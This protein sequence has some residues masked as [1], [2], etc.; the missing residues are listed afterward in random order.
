MINNQVRDECIAPAG[1]G[2][3]R[4]MA[5]M[6]GEQAATSLLFNVPPGRAGAS[7]GRSGGRVNVLLTRGERRGL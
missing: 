5:E 2:T 6:N 7:G 4:N 3:A 1:G